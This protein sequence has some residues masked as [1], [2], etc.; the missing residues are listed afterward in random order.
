MLISEDGR[1]SPTACRPAEGDGFQI[2]SSDRACTR[3][4][5]QDSVRAAPPWSGATDADRHL[6]PASAGGSRA[7]FAAVRAR[8]IAAADD[9]R[10]RIERDLHDGLQQQL[11]CLGLRVRLA[12]ASIPPGHEELKCELDRISEGLKEALEN[13]REI[14]RG[15]HP[16]ILSQCGLGPAVKAL[17]HR[18]PVPVRLSADISGRL[19][20]PVEIG[21]YYIVGEA[22]ANAAKHSNASVVDISIEQRGQFLALA[23]Q[24]DG[25]GG[26]DGNGPGLTGLTDRIDALAG[27][28]QLLSPPGR[29]TH[30]FVNLPTGTAPTVAARGRGR[31][32]EK[33]P[34]G[35]S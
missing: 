29:G 9:A 31:P 20:D 33:R 6:E 17:A 12:E 22:L 19:P 16:A 11:V 13:V 30:L 8:I 4:E 26:A 24:D 34:P 25:V 1:R 21:A 27:T 32:Q 10:R 18:S 7:E 5:Y 15:L 2:P 14:S 3:P 35:T 23:V 28:M